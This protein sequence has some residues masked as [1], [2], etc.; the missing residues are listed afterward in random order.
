MCDLLSMPC[1]AATLCL[2]IRT[3]ADLLNHGDESMQFRPSQARILA[4]V[5]LL[6]D[7]QRVVGTGRRCWSALA[8][9]GRVCDSVVGEHPWRAYRLNSI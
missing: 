1:C 7:Q 3:A 9:W 6:T 5:G 8:Q 2:G 4:V